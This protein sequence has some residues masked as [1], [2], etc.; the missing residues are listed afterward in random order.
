MTIIDW[1]GADIPE[2]LRKLPAGKYVV[3]SVT[4]VLS[5]DEEDGLIAALESLRV[6]RSFSHE[7]VREDL[8]RRAPL[9]IF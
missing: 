1:N 9:K 4:E 7:E 2:E 6:G 8:Q 5:S 3:A